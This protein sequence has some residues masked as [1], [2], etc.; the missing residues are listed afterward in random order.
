MI[1]SDIINKVAKDLNLSQD[2]VQKTYSAYWRT[3]KEHIASLP[4]KK[5][6]SKKEFKKLQPNINIPSIGKLY[7]TY[8]RY[9]RLKERDRIIKDII[10]SKSNVAH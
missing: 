8:D 10:K 4:L 6:L 5:N 1:D 9:K 7:I 2:L 3:I